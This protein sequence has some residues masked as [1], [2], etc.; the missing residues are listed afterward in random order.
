MLDR[1]RDIADEIF[2]RL[3]LGVRDEQVVVSLTGAMRRMLRT[4]GNPPV[5]LPGPGDGLVGAIGLLLAAGLEP[6]QRASFLADP[7]GQWAGEIVGETLRLEPPASGVLR[8][9]REPFPAGGWLPAG[10][11]VLVP[12]TLMHRDERFYFP[13]GGGARRCIGEALAL[14]EIETV[15]PA[16]LGQLRLTPLAEEPEPMVQRATVLAPKRGL[17]THAA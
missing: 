15:V 9:L 2:V 6:E 17:L 12:T 5:T 4:P 10:A 8:K 3:L 14:T 11:T 7:R 1:V 16:V 13:F